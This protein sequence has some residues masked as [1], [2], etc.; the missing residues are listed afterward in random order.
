MDA[1]QREEL[2]AGWRRAVARAAGW[3]LPPAGQCTRFSLAF[4]YFHQNP[5][6]GGE[7]D[8]QAATMKKEVEIMKRFAVVIALTVI[9]F[10]CLTGSVSPRR[11]RMSFTS[12]P[13]LQGRPRSGPKGVR[14]FREKEVQ[15]G[16]QDQR[17]AAGDAVAYGQIVEWKGKPRRTCSGR[18][19]NAVRPAGRPGPPGQGD[20][21]Q[22]DVDEIRPRSANPSGFPEGPKGFWVGTTL[23]PYGLIYQ[24]TLLKRL[25]VEIKDWDDLLNP[26]LKGHI[27]QCTPDRSSSS[28]A[29]Y[30]V[31]LAMHGWRRGGVADQAGGQHG[32]LHGPLT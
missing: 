14:G 3:A 2:F 19:G 6:P 28:H 5:Q 16:S 23:E 7:S 10:F 24:P 18:R 22:G 26:K 9:G 4:F 21:P 12:S 25:G 32:D 20:P 8:V 27:A 29:S 15:R 30:E 13:G 17:D 31:I 1:T 11:S